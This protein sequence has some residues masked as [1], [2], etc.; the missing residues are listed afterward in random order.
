MIKQR[1]KSPDTGS[2]LSGAFSTKRQPDINNET[3][4][5]EKNTKPLFIDESTVKL[6]NIN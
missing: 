3:N 4:V 5:E 2:Y 1:K 6:L